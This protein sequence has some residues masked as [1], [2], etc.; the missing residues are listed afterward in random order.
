MATL[1]KQER[2]NYERWLE[3]AWYAGNLTKDIGHDSMGNKVC[4]VTDPIEDLVC[5]IPT[6]ADARTI[7]Q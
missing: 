4:I 7:E 6:E 5:N 1:N 2:D 3:T